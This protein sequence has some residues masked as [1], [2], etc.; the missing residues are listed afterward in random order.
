MYSKPGQPEFKYTA[1]TPTQQAHR[2][3]SRSIESQLK[4][5][6]NTF[7]PS[8]RSYS[9]D[10]DGETGESHYMQSATTDVFSLGIPSLQSGLYPSS[11]FEDTLHQNPQS[12]LSFSPQAAFPDASATDFWG[13]TLQS[14]EPLWHHEQSDQM[15]IGHTE[16]SEKVRCDGS[17]NAG[18]QSVA[19]ENVDEQSLVSRGR[20]ASRTTLVLEDVEP[21]TLK[22]VI[23]RLFKAKTKIHMKTCQ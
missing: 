6:F 3:I 1:S 14:A 9:D 16:N 10:F 4:P 21:E 13:E 15:T 11:S 19:S 7:P 23:D 20:Q 18:A 8:K 5:S 12:Q 2:L 17:S 22:T